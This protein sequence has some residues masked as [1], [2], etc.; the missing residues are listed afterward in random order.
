MSNPVI[1]YGKRRDKQRAEEMAAEEIGANKRLNWIKKE[2]LSEFET[3]FADVL[4]DIKDSGITYSIGFNDEKYPDSNKHIKFH[5]HE[6]KVT[7]KMDWAGPKCYRYCHTSS[8]NDYTTMCYGEWPVEDLLGYL[9]DRIFKQ[10][11]F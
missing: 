5:H 9:Y 1:E 10:L 2:T 6:G 3:V 11:P 7:C 4:Q 8:I